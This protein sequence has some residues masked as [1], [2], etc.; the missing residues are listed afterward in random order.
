MYVGWYFVNTT[1]YSNYY[2]LDVNFIVERYANEKETHQF[3]TD[4]DM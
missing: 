4:T 1:E 3:K 2:Y